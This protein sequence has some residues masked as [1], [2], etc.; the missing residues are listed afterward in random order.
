MS[1]EIPGPNE[2][3]IATVYRAQSIAAEYGHEYVTLEHL[4]A[5]LM[6]QEE[7]VKTL[8][9]LNIDSDDV[10]AEVK[11][12]LSTDAI[13]VTHT[14]PRPT[15]AF[16]ELITRSVASTILV[17]NHSKVKPVDMLLN[18][19]LM[20]EDDC[21]AVHLMMKMG[22]TS[23][24]LKKL[25]SHGSPKAD[26]RHQRQMEDGTGIPSSSAPLTTREEAE[27]YIEQYATN[28]NKKALEATIDPLIG[29]TKEVAEIIQITARR[30]KNNS[31][32]VGE[33]GVGKTAIAEGLALKI[34]RKEV[35]DV[36]LPCVVYALDIGSLVAGT[37]FRG[38]FEER[39]KQVI[40]AAELIPDS[41]LFID[42]IHTVMGAGNS[43]GSSLDV[44]NLLK[45]ALAKGTLRCIGSTTLEEFRKHFEK[46]RA[47][48]RRFKKVDVNEPTNE[49]AKLILR[50][51]RPYYEDFHKVK[52]SDAALDAA[53]DLTQRYVNGAFL[54]DKAIDVIDNAGARQRVAPD[55]EKLV[56]IG[57]TEIEVEV[58]KVA[59][60]PAQAVAEDESHRLGRLE[61]DL[62][63]GVIGQDNAIIELADAVFMSRAGLRETNK[64]SGSYLF[65]G[66]TGVGKTEAARTL[67]KTLGVPLIKYDM[68]EYME[69]HSVSKLIGAPPGYVG[70]GEGNAGS[71]KLV[72]DIDSTPHCVLLLDEIEKAHPDVF[73]ILLQVMDDGKLSS[74][75]GKVVSFRNVILIMTSNAGA[76]E[77]TKN[78]IG[79]GAK[80]NVD[81][82]EPAIKKT[83]SPEFRNRLDAIVKFGR[84]KP[85]NMLVIVNK[86]VHQ[87]IEMTTERGV[88][89]DIDDE[90]RQWL[91]TKGYDKD[92]G[93][94]PLQRVIAD[95]IKKPLSRLMVTGP[96]AKGGLA[97]VRVVDEKLLVSA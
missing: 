91:A 27:A 36:I 41:I 67:A 25:L 8:K 63:I 75:V 46:D 33:P 66:P 53:V 60:I 97:K 11:D 37:R 56:E 58:A 65:T 77:L 32:L 4:L 10:A 83:F 18:L 52:F 14:Q 62:R 47:L 61:D 89:I 1:D 82:D 28:L 86:F 70:Y 90:A 96:L 31:V 24:A 92:M 50:G 39:M 55:A 78:L 5:A 48:L 69:K 73:N 74:S 76:A 21:F 29:R 6:E 79:F 84:L 59:H 93:A 17:M 20:P 16:D 15:G 80:D 43:G 30:T 72:N 94:R 88:T 19:A 26:Q 64:P 22:I 13:P 42:E 45:P 34:V 35:P 49:D 7:I 81:G 95:N 9:Q 57:V 71:G 3:T 23:L 54:P 40:K 2:Q 85:E 68:S 87:L 51:L 12:Y 44:A 38:D